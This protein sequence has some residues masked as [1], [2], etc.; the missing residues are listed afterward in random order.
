M[1][2]QVKQIFKPEF[3]NRLSSTVVF[4]DMTKEMAQ[5]ILDKKLKQ[6]QEKLDAK[7]VQLELTDAAYT[8]LLE[9]GF[10][11]E[12]GAREMDRVVAQYLK[13]LLMKAILFG[14]LKKGG[15][16]LVDAQNDALMIAAN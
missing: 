2:K 10:T 15:E 16:A 11:P 1:V 4:H 9:K 8:W 12:Y 14:K 3:I 5:M 6:F 7:H 13:P